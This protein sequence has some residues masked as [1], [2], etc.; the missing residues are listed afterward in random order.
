MPIFIPKFKTGYFAETIKMG[1]ERRSGN[2][3]YSLSKKHTEILFLKAVTSTHN[4][5]DGQLNVKM[6]FLP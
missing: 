5:I 4:Y 3:R 6:F 2:F 1:A